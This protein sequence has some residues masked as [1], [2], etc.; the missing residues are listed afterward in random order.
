[1]AQKLVLRE[2]SGGRCALILTGP[3]VFGILVSGPH[4]SGP[5]WALHGLASEFVIF[6]FFPNRT[7]E[8]PKS[9]IS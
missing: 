6:A 2:L 5:L 7:P 8:A 9:Q 1:M 4:M 3:F